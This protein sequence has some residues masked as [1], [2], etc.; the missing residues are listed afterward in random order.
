MAFSG[1]G[2]SEEILNHRLSE[3]PVDQEIISVHLFCDPLYPLVFNALDGMTRILPE[4]LKRQW[5]FCLYGL[6]GSHLRFRVLVLHREER[7]FL[8][9]FLMKCASDLV[10]EMRQQDG[11]LIASSDLANPPQIGFGDEREVLRRR[12]NLILRECATEWDRTLYAPGSVN[13]APYIPEFERYGGA[14]HYPATIKW[15]CLTSRKCFW[16]IGEA[17]NRV[18]RL[19]LVALLMA[20]LLSLSQAYSNSAEL[21]ALP[22]Q[23][24]LYWARQCASI[25]RTTLKS[26]AA[27]SKWWIDSITEFRRLDLLLGR[28]DWKYMRLHLHMIANRLDL[29]N[30][31]ELSVLKAAAHLCEP[32]SAGE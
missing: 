26:N 22:S 11:A 3:L 10:S 25:A 14:G 6:G 29:T 31:E 27:V 13:L 4:R 21:L 5:F 20:A 2:S 9:P 17:R 32:E 24:H 30:L 15:F 7:E 12:T 18:E 23:T 16:V 28:M 8:T 1:K 19:I